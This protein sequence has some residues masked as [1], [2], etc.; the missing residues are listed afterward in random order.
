MA[1]AFVPASAVA[2]AAKYLDDG[3]KI[4]G[5]LGVPTALCTSLLVV[6]QEL[7]AVASELVLEEV[8]GEATKSVAVADGNTADLALVR[9]VQKGEQPR[10]PEVEPRA[11][12]ADDSP[13]RVGL[14]HVM[15]LSL[16]IVLLF[17][18]RDPSID[19]SFSSRCGVVA[20]QRCC[21]V[22]DTA[23]TRAESRADFA[24]R[25]PSSEG[26]GRHSE[27]LPGLSSGGPSALRFIHDYGGW[28]RVD[29]I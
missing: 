20:G 23:S 28:V 2:S 11:N 29:R 25:C 10:S 26:A 7:H 15:H 17:R 3:E 13:A 21:E 1:G 16:K 22:V 4:V 12:I 27:R 18:R 6:D 14:V 5:E 8:E 19:D 24:R 9:E